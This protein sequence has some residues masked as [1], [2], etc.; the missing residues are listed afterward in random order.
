MLKEVNNERKGTEGGRGFVY[1]NELLKPSEMVHVKE[2]DN[3]E[4][5]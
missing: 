1:M 5:L 4:S 3:I 2:E